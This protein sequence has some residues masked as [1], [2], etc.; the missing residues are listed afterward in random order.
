MK[1][2]Y[3]VTNHGYG[4][5]VRTATIV[6]ALPAATHIVF[7]TTLPEAFFH[8]VVRR[9]FTY[10]SAAFDCGC[11]QKDGIRSNIEATLVAYR[12]IAKR[13]EKLL[14]REAAWCRAQYPTLIVS[15]IVPFAFEV[16]Q[17]C[18]IPSVAVTNFTWYDIYKKYCANFPAYGPLLGPLQQ[19]YASASMLLS[20]DPALPMHYFPVR[21]KIALVGRQGLKRRGDIVQHYKLDSAKHIGLL[22]MGQLGIEGFDWQAIERFS[23]WEF[24]GI[25]TADSLPANYR[26]VGKID[27]PYQDLVASVDCMV[28]KLGY[29]TVAEAMLHGTPMIY[30]PRDDFAEFEVLDAAVRQW[31]GGVCL[32]TKAFTKCEWR[33]ALDR[34]IAWRRRPLP[35]KSDGAEHAAACIVHLAS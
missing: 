23:D 11:I 9:K 19:Q 16:A 20:L 12:D 27:F 32:T 21:T 8:E 14:D 18:G 3:Y 33:E 29:S 4:H 25:S 35:I 6:N 5:G 1:I 34:S 2:I 22:Y 10:A 15:D 17:A 26:R 31:G 30:L 28:G 13:N 24:L 7:R